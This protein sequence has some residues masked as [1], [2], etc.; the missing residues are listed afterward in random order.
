M[1]F[2]SL[3]LYNLFL[4][5][6]RVGARILG[7]FNKKAKLWVLG[8]MNIF[9]KLKNAFKENHAPIAWFHCASLGEFEQGRP[10]IEKLKKENPEYKILV[11][12]F[13][14]SGYEIRKNYS[15]ADWVF[16]LP[17]DGKINAYRFME[18]VKPSLAFFIKYEF[19][20]FYLA[21]LKKRNIPLFLVSG[22][23][24][25]SQPFFKWYGAWQRKALTFFK[26]FFVQKKHSA[27]L[28]QTLGFENATVT[29]DT[30]FDRVIAT[31]NSWTSIE[32]LEKFCGDKKVLVA[33]ST[34]EEDD[35]VLK[36]YVIAHPEVRFIIAPHEI[37]PARIKECKEIYENATL[38][39]D[40]IK[41]EEIPHNINTLIIDNIGMLNR[42]YKYAQIS[43]VG[44]AF[45]NG[46]HNVLEP[47]VF[48]TPIL[49][50]PDYE[51]FPET[52]DL[53]ELKIGFSVNNALECEKII[54]ELMNDSK[55]LSLIH[56]M[57]EEYIKENI[58]ATEKIFI[59]LHENNIL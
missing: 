17:T 10:L 53:I 39:S 59:Y 26:H 6:Y 50:G 12:F 47:L 37:G 3:L 44:G 49:F 4:W 23:F 8:R 11:T 42:L 21:E 34:W 22:V 33:G 31:K 54:T 16:Y 30:R 9:S 40:F 38:Y 5:L 41:K 43:Y 18:I 45:G 15:L 28:L 36:H 24:R 52:N 48:G 20:Y 2:I 58:G 7:L 25:T 14:P 32:S 46:I 13:S 29:G 51:N 55:K 1:N 27:I 56:N 57:A 19:W 35:L